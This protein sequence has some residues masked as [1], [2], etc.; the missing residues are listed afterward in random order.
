M[1]IHEYLTSYIEYLS[2]E[3]R[4]SPHT[5]LNYQR[6]VSAF[7]VYLK[8]THLSELEEA[9]KEMLR[10]YVMFLSDQGKSEKTINRNISSLRGFYKF[11]IKVE[12]INLNPTLGL[13]S[14]KVKK[15]IQIPLSVEEMEKEI[16][17]QAHLTAF[18]NLRNGLLIELFYQTGIRRQELID[19]CVKDI[20]MYAQMLKVTG[21]R[22]KQRL[23]PLS[24]DFTSQLKS[25]I[26]KLPLSGSDSP[27][28]QL[29]SGKKL[30]PKLVYS[31]V[32]HYISKVSNKEKKSPH[33]LRH[34]FATHMLNNGADLN[35][36]KEL[37]GH[38]SLAATQVYTHSNIEDLKKVFNQSHP[39]EKKN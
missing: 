6:D 35:T 22:S 15:R 29:K 7:A 2:F 25:F 12:L 14:L 18:E 8:E 38:T 32:N 9:E 36:I 31:V 13:S 34:T 23:V 3:K 4:Y 21:K 5:T 1:S 16:P 20:D 19:L 27:L 26:L 28:F 39:R 37:L 17:Q 11:L 33:I 24:P 10:S 30:Y